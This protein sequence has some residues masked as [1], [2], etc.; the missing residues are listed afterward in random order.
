MKIQSNPASYMTQHPPAAQRANAQE[1][2]KNT[3]A[4]A[5]VAQTNNNASSPVQRADLTNMTPMD[6][7]NWLNDQIRTGKMTLDESTPFMGMT[8]GAEADNSPVNYLQKIKGGIEA[9]TWRGNA[10]SKAMWKMALNIAERYQY[11]NIGIRTF[12]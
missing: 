1:S 11:Q 10:E 8:I 6:M 3:L 12:A 2:F 4:S 5:E 7:R 9:A